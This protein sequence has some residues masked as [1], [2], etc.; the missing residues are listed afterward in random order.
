MKAVVAAF[1]QEKALVA[2]FSVITNL[3]MELFEALVMYHTGAL[4]QAG[5]RKSLQSSHSTTRHLVTVTTE[6]TG[7]AR[8]EHCRVVV[9]TCI[10]DTG[11]MEISCVCR[12]GDI[13]CV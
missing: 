10:G 2:A 3:Q 5:S 6:Q 1:N 13:L 7:T 11:D 4:T 9:C 8:G 12:Y